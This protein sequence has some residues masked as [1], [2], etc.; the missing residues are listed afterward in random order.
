MFHFNPSGV[1]DV[2]D[3]HVEVETGNV[4]MQMQCGPMV[5]PHSLRNFFLYVVMSL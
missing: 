2:D 3:Y 1:A 5:G 4:E